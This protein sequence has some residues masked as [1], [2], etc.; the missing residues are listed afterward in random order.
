MIFKNLS[1]VSL[2]ISIVFYF[3]LIDFGIVVYSVITESSQVINLY[4]V[5]LTFLAVTGVGVLKYGP[6]HNINNDT[7]ISVIFYLLLLDFFVVT[8]L[9]VTESSTSITATDG[10]LVFVAILTT[11]YL[12]YRKGSINKLE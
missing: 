3:L 8:Y 9:V 10:V 5:I 6:Y 12:K 4:D 11:G 2:L 7:I 1:F